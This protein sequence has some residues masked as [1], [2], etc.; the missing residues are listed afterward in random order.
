MGHAYTYTIAAP[1]HQ[2]VSSS[3]HGG[4]RSVGMVSKISSAAAEYIRG[5]ISSIASLLP[6]EVRAIRATLSAPCGCTTS[7]QVA[8]AT[9]PPLC[10]APG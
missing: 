9:R 4:G 3:P 5:E 2:R 10:R 6:L 8:S 1:G 7:F